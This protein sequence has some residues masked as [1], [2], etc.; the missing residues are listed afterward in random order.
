M[1]TVHILT[2]R[3][4]AQ[5]VRGLNICIQTNSQDVNLLRIHNPTTILIETATKVVYVIKRRAHR[6]LLAR[7][8]GRSRPHSS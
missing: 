5:L 1:F 6:Q 8:V 3:I 2:T 7:G 4:E